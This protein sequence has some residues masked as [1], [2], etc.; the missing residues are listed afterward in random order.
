MTKAGSSAQN[1][2]TPPRNL[3]SGGLRGL[4]PI[5]RLHQYPVLKDFY[6]QVRVLSTPNEKKVEG[7]PVLADSIFKKESQKAKSERFTG[8]H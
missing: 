3:P 6:Y 8:F 7:S 5:L 4:L 2:E 1:F